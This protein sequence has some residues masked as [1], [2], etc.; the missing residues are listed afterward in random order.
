MSTITTPRAPSF[1]KETAMALPSPRAPP[2][3]NATPGASG[4]ERF[5]ILSVLV[6]VN[7]QLKE[8][9]IELKGP[10]IAARES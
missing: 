7:F 4:P 2:V 6:M 8:V 1:A 3:M 9:V 10:S 5:D